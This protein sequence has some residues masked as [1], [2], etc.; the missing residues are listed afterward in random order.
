MTDAQLTAAQHARVRK[1]LASVPYAKFLG[2]KIDQIAVGSATLSLKVRDELK[3]NRGVVHGGAIASLIDSATAFAII[4]M[5]E[6]EESTTTVDMTISY[7]RPVTRGRMTA[8]AKVTRAGR[9]IIAVSAEA[10]DDK[11]T[12]VAT[13]LSTY[14]KL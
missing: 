1:A 3:Q 8:T 5:L 2:I 11:Q 6:P 4:S 9:R 14:I 13:S 10:F 12:L 7:L